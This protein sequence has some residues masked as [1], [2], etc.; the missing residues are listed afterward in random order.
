MLRV[1]DGLWLLTGSL[2]CCVQ[3]NLHM[4]LKES[5]YEKLCRWVTTPFLGGSTGPCA[6]RLWSAASCHVAARR[7]VLLPFGP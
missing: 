5:W 7:A 4:E 6:V 3:K 1:M 2:C